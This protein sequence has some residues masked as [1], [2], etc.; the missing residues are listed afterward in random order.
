M[1]THPQFLHIRWFLLCGI[2]GSVLTGNIQAGVQTSPEKIVLENRVARME[3]NRFGGAISSF[4]LLE[5]EQ[6][7]YSWVSGR[8][9]ARDV[10]RK[11]GLFV[12][13][14]RLG[15]ST[16][17][18]HAAGMPFHGEATSVPWKLL[19]H[20]E[21]NGTC[22]VMLECRLPIAKMSLE[23]TVELFDHSSVCR[24]TDRVTNHNHFRKPFNMMQHPSI[25]PSFLNESVRADCNASDG[26]LN[27]RNMEDMPGR[28]YPWPEMSVGGHELDMRRG[29]P[30]VRA[31]GSYLCEAGC[32][33]GWG[34]VSNPKQGVLAGNLWSAADYPWI[35]IWREWNDTAPMA[36][37][38]EFST[39]CFGKPFVAI[40][41]KG[42]VLE[43][44]VLEYLNPQESCSKTFYTY[45]CK[46]PADYQGVQHVEKT[47]T[48]L[49]ITEYQTGRKIT[50]PLQGKN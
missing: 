2:A 6:N 21:S 30:G 50:L 1:V 20:A 41:A 31:V 7:P 23:R 18:E 25:G 40:E 10:S 47:G 28:I 4:V 34:T 3:I 33:D 5:N 14:D 9:K 22:L 19:K 43:T 45:L 16:A 11:E 13:F 46:I 26:F 8:W 12:C 24:I 37:G 48:H 29:L 32:S 44:A 39:T 42:P 35:R 17:E 27:T 15:V 49:M 38:V 36:L